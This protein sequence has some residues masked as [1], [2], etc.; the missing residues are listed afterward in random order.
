VK[1]RE[2]S[3]VLKSELNR[4]N[5]LLRLKPAGVARTFLP[6]GKRLGLT[7]EECKVGERGWICERWLGSETEADNDVKL[8]NEGLSYIDIE[9]HEI[10]LSDA[11]ESAGGQILGEEY[12]KTHKNLGRLAK[13]YDYKCRLFYHIHQTQ[14]EASKVGATSK[15]EAYFFPEGVDL[16]PHPETF[17]G[18]HP[19]IVEQNLQSE[20]FLPALKEWDSEKLL[21]HSRAYMNVPGEGFHLP[22]GVLHAPGSAVTIELQE[23]S[24]VMAVFQSTVE[25]T[26][27]SKEMLFKDIDKKAREEKGEQAALDQLDWEINGDPYFYENRH[28]PPILIEDKASEGSREYWIYYNTKKFSGKRLVISPGQKVISS[29]AG[30]HNILVWRGRGKAE[31]LEIEG[32]NFG[33]D[34]L[35]V[36]HSKAV[37]GVLYE[38][39]GDVDLEILKFFGPDVNNERVPYLKKYPG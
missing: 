36:S 23:P 19:Y 4:N 3:E 34:E 30:V 35:L 26:K 24:D 38:N 20:L 10:L 8:K 14:E 25:G 9:G 37:R 2:I 17:F 5:G 15:E 11:V 7:N 31:G 21:M 29:D 6:P 13:I 39:T 12:A 1:S 28:T 33:K 27:I 18:V 22:A 32:Q 16:G